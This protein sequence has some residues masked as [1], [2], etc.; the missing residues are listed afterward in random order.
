MITCGNCEAMMRNTLRMHTTKLV[1][2]I[3]SLLQRWMEWTSHCVTFAVAVVRN[4]Y[5]SNSENCAHN[6]NRVPLFYC[7]HVGPPGI[8]DC[9]PIIVI[10]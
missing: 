3:I 4:M 10:M 6:D 2:F 9:P 7:D 5:M 1:T 8:L